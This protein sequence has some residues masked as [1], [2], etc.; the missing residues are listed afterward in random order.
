MYDDVGGLYAEPLTP[1]QEAIPIAVGQYP[2]GAE[3]SPDGRWVA[4]STNE[5]GT[6]QVYL[7][8]FP[9]STR[10]IQVSID[11]GIRPR[12]RGDGRELFYLSADT[13]L[14][15]VD[16][17]GGGKAFVSQ[18]EEVFSLPEGIEAFDVTP[19]GERFL[20][21]ARLENQASAPLTVGLNWTEELE[22]R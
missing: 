20:V 11:S 13:H 18:P 9:P 8:S 1:G 10:R 4:Y 3:F 7:E 12:W 2:L 6:F 17:S 14:M 22:G 19:D 21:V 15:S 16:I 5:T